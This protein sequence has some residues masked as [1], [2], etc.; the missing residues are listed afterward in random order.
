MVEIGV[1]TSVAA[2]GQ[3]Q[4]VVHT[5]SFTIRRHLCI[6]GGKQQISTSSRDKVIAKYP[7]IENVYSG[8]QWRAFRSELETR[9]SE[10]QKSDCGAHVLATSYKA[11][12]VRMTRPAWPLFGNGRPF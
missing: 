10:R 3:I 12:F 8:G 9:E 6:K 11:G 2:T 1:H 5:L 4:I 7:V